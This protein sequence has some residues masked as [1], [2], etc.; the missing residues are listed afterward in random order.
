MKTYPLGDRH[1]QQKFG[2]LH[3]IGAEGDKR[4]RA[5]NS[6]IKRAPKKG[7]WYISGALPCAYRA[8]HD[9]TIAYYIASIVEVEEK[10]TIDIKRVL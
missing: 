8:A 5:I 3:S 6:G 7:E 2:P 10:T 1:P 4:I 9:L